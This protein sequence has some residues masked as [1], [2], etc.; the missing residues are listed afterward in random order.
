MRH[1]PR[2]SILQ[3]Y[4]TSPDEAA[5]VALLVTSDSA[6]VARRRRDR[7]R[8]V[9]LLGRIYFSACATPCATVTAVCV[10]FFSFSSGGESNW[11]LGQ[12]PHVF[13]PFV[14]TLFLFDYVK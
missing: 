14:Q 1:R 12:N 4:A 6:S 11:V 9:Q 3:L 10:G 8:M 13:L 2:I 5:E 7:Q